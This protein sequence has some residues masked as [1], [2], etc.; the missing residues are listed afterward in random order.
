M[1]MHIYTEHT[2]LKNLATSPYVSWQWGIVIAREI[3]LDKQV[4]PFHVV[5]HYYGNMVQFT[6]CGCEL[7]RTHLYIIFL[8]ISNVN[9]V[10]AGALIIALISAPVVFFLQVMHL[11]KLYALYTGISLHFSFTN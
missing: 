6:L 4:Q 5:K 10:M 8:C 2:S 11:P 9:F 1:R 7:F 3:T